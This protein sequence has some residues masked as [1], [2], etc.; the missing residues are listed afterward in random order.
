MSQQEATE[1]SV[2]EPVSGF[3]EIARQL[4]LSKEEALTAS[5]KTPETTEEPK[6][7]E[8]VKSDEEGKKLVDNYSK[9]IQEASEELYATYLVRA[10]ED[11]NF[12]SRLISS[13]ESPKLK[14]AAKILKNN[15]E[16]GAS[17]IEEFT[18]N[19]VRNQAGD[20]PLAQDRAELKEVLENFKR[21]TAKTQWET[22]KERNQ[23]TGEFA[24]L[25]DQIHSEHPS[26]P[27]GDVAILAKGRMG[28]ATVNRA[29]TA[30]PLGG[31]SLP[32]DTKPKFDMAM[33]RRMHLTEKDLEKFL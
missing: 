30:L 5:P 11:E 28:G 24:T 12:L 31:V 32:S 20:D 13:K 21:E 27:F 23:V 1:T 26:L 22:Q 16:F 17:T 8:Q 2:G 4:G 25:V 14:M 19:S 10:K 3:Q 6:S 9:L 15:P 7:K 29:S 18:R 33:A